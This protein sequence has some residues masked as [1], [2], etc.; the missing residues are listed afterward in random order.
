[1]QNDGLFDEPFWADSNKTG[2]GND[3]LAWRIAE[4]AF[5]IHVDKTSDVADGFTNFSE[6]VIQR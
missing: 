2:D 6:E 1:M 3:E 5:F 4:Q